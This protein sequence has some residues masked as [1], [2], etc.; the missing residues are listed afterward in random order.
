MPRLIVEWDAG[1]EVFELDQQEYEEYLEAREDP[2]FYFDSYV[3]DVWP[4]KYARVVE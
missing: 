1:Q 2:D 3:S 4:E